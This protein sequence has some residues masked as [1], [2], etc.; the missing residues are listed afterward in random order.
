MTGLNPSTAYEVTVA[1]HHPLQH[2]LRRWFIA[3]EA[4]AASNASA[5]A[6]TAAYA[7]AYAAAVAGNKSTGVHNATLQSLRAAVD[8]H[9]LALSQALNATVRG[10]LPCPYYNETEYIARAL[11]TVQ[12]PWPHNASHAKATNYTSPPCDWTGSGHHTAAAV[13][14]VTRPVA[15]AT[16]KVVDARVALSYAASGTLRGVLAEAIAGGC[17]SPISLP[18]PPPPPPLTNTTS[19]SY[20][21]EHDN[22]ELFYGL[23]LT[24]ASEGVNRGGVMG[25]GSVRRALSSSSSSS[26]STNTASAAASVVDSWSSSSLSS[27]F[28]GLQS[29]EED[30]TPTRRVCFDTAAAVEALR[31]TETSSKAAVPASVRYSGAIGAHRNTTATAVSALA[32]LTPTGGTGVFCETAKAV[33]GGDDVGGGGGSMGVE[34]QEA[35]DVGRGGVVC[36]AARAKA[37]LDAAVEAGRA[38]ISAERAWAAS[39]RLVR[40]YTPHR[41][42]TEDTA[43]VGG[44]VVPALSAPGSFTGGGV[45]EYQLNTHTKG[46]SGDSSGGGG[47]VATSTFTTSTEAAPPL[48]SRASTGYERVVVVIGEA[49]G[50]VSLGSFSGD[51]FFPPNALG[52]DVSVGFK[53]EDPRGGTENASLTAPPVPGFGGSLGFAGPVYTLTPH[54]IGFRRPVRLRLAYDATWGWLGADANDPTGVGIGDLTVMRRKDESSGSKWENLLVGNRSAIGGVTFQG[55]S[56]TLFVDGFS[57]YAVA[58]VLPPPPPPSPPP[59]SPS[60]PPSPRPPPAPNPCIP[61]D[62]PDNFTLV[63]VTVLVMAPP[64]PPPK[65]PPPSPPSPPPSPR[66]PPSYTPSPP[67]TASPPP[68]SPPPPPFPPPPTPLPP[69]PSPPPPVPSP[70]PGGGALVNGTSNG[71]LNGNT[72][73]G[74]DSTTANVTY[75][76][77]TQTWQY[78]N[79]TRVYGRFLCPYPPPP[80]AGESP[81]FIFDFTTVQWILFGS[82]AAFGACCACCTTYVKILAKKTQREMRI[83]VEGEGA[84]DADSESDDEEAA[85]KRKKEEKKAKAK[86]KKASGGADDDDEEEEEAAAE[87]LRLREKM[88]PTLD[89]R[90]AAMNL[91]EAA[92]AAYIKEDYAAAVTMLTEA[93]EN[94]PLDG[95]LHQLRSSCYLALAA[96]KDF[97]GRKEKKKKYNLPKVPKKP[98]GK[99]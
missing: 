45:T 67:P 74:S 73:T 23:Q 76:N 60:P 46:D 29:M 83:A 40:L 95:D 7:S 47:G 11:D 64:P 44:G 80:P 53:A 86:K 48:G 3:G 63:N 56:A 66:P 32:D 9:T 59:P 77:V 89:T 2:M 71:T 16:K 12:A 34:A 15:A 68:P 42:A 75:V 5:I 99:K 84:V 58:Q 25:R 98:G 13:L 22:H 50:V 28:Y 1:V 26:S 94:D 52:A 57:Q 88:E 6:A 79:G 91:K 19:Q 35:S 70:P 24:A 30:A 82:I 61:R 31:A 55:G 78:L 62:G 96:S 36:P 17:G 49:G 20:F 8:A 65:P 92:R 81:P 85:R 38:L 33:E 14:N 72:T 41:I 18:S 10:D 90:L 4:A 87:R 93:I 97:G 27:F 21:S 37:A 69:P 54:G 43:S 51:V 39:Q